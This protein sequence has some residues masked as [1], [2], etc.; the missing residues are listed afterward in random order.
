MYIGFFHTQSSKSLNRFTL[1]T[2]RGNIRRSWNWLFIIRLKFQIMCCLR[3]LRRRS[4]SFWN[5]EKIAQN[6]GLMSLDLWKRHFWLVISIQRL[7]FA[8]CNKHVLHFI[9]RSSVFSLCSE[10]KSISYA[11]NILNAG[12]CHICQLHSTDLSCFDKELSWRAVKIAGIRSYS[13]I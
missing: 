7:F 8:S 3:Y 2:F 5:R 9:R 12:F 11:V 10:L 13:T 1:F 6:I 4:L